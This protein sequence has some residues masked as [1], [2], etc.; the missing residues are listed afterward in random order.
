MS[1][2]GCLH[3]L[4]W[5][6]AER[7]PDA[8]A[9]ESEESVLTY[10]ELHLAARRLARRLRDRGVGP[11]TRVGVCM[12][13]SVRLVVALLAILEAEG[14]YVPLDP[15]YPPERLEFMS[16][17]AR[18]ALLLADA[19][20]PPAMTSAAARVLVLDDADGAPVDPGLPALAASPDRLAYLVYTS[21]ST[22]RPKGVMVSHRAIRN[23]T[24]WLQDAFPLGPADRLLHKTPMGFDPSI[25]EFFAP[26]VAGARLVLARHDGHQDPAYLVDTIIE[27]RITALQ[28]VPTLLGML[29]EQPRLAECRTLRLVLSGGEAL[30]LDLVDRLHSRLPV[31][32]H[33][34]YGPTE[35][36][37]DATCQPRV[38]RA[39]AGIAPIGR[40]IA[41][42]TAH[43]LD[44][45]MRP[46][47]DGEP[48]ELFLGGLLLA[49]GYQGRAGQTA[50]RFLPNPFAATA[51]P[52]ELRLYRTGDV[53]RRL[54]GGALELLGRTDQQIKVRGVR[55]EPG[56]I[57]AA[58]REHPAVREAVAVALDQPAGQRLVAYVGAGPDAG[59]RAGR[60]LG[61]RLRGRLSDRLPTHLVPTTI[62]V[63]DALP[64]TPGGKLD[65]LG[66]PIPGEFEVPDDAQHVA[67]RTPLE[68]EL[69]GD[70][71]RLLGV[72]RIGVEDDLFDLGAD[73]VLV[74][75][76]GTHV[77]A[78]YGIRLP[79]YLLFTV[80]TV[81]GVAEAVETCARDGGSQAAAAAVSV[82]QA[83][84]VLDAGLVPR[85]DA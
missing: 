2:E 36:A 13:R 53:A 54:P 30:P 9:V 46:V 27:R 28:V 23:H 8:V 68:V 1:R 24:L 73:S 17:D 16:Q 80:P 6:Q 11:E 51:T 7:A 71:A 38:G 75:R 74:A 85:W 83:E 39:A 34:L 62:V 84:A 15:A 64:R 79:L 45:D 26:L 56:E 66:L 76:L 69:A 3:D 25:T 78:R 33:N 10:S 32:I 72:T 20:T 29:V 37:I 5:K 18:V 42:A 70:F 55:I 14:A 59:E 52:P 22:G 50:E 58:L 47:A 60:E 19:G 12:E 4:V 61:R 57:E 43:I 40:P 67:P 63:L 41:N 48:G 49:R 31:E 77:L 44:R 81:A 65:R 35:A 21:G 82:L